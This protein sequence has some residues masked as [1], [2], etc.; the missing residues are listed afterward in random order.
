MKVRVEMTGGAVVV[1]MVV[2]CRKAQRETESSS[3]FTSCNKQTHQNQ[4][5][6]QPQKQQQQQHTK[7]SLFAASQEQ[8]FPNCFE[9]DLLD[10]SSSSSSSRSG[11]GSAGIKPEESPA[12]RSHC[13]NLSLS[14]AATL[15]KSD[16]L[17]DAPLFRRWGLR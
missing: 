11:A 17:V 1:V 15:N 12:G 2:D 6:Q 9:G 3:T 13:C 5:Q 10:S 7:S 16:T 4:Q 8:R 14:L